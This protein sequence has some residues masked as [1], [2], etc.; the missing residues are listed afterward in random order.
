MNGQEVV[1]VELRGGMA[2][3]RQFEVG[4]CHAGAVVGD[5][6]QS[7]AAAIGQHLDAAR[8]GIERVLDQFLDHARRT[9]DH[10]AGGDAVDDG[11]RQL[12]DGHFSSF[13]SPRLAVERENGGDSITRSIAPQAGQP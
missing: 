12:A 3:D 7:P 13:A 4:A 8:T 1:A 2:F 10:L 5:A 11:F 9:L 6:D